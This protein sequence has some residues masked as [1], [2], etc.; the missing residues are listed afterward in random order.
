MNEQNKSIIKEGLAKLALVL[1]ALLTIITCA[2][3]WNYCPE[4]TVNILST[5]LLACNFTA[6]VKLWKKTETTPRSGESP[7]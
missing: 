2:G 1:Y 4:T 7:K 3:V 6:I 5:A